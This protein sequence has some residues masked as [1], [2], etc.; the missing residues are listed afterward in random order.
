M[1]TTRRFEGGLRLRRGRR[2][3]VARLR[4]LVPAPLEPRAERF[5]RRTLADLGHDVYVA[6]APDGALVGV[7]AVGYVRSLQQGRHT[8]VLDTARVEPGNGALLEA[9]LDLAEERARRR[10]CRQVRAWPGPE[11]DGLRAAL[12]TRGWRGGDI[13]IGELTRQAECRRSS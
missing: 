1:G 13:L 10:G 6:E 4:R 9:L 12:A 5:D 2:T 8:A 7:V 3:D 11:D